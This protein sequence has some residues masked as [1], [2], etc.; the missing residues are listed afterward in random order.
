MTIDV[1]GNHCMIVVRCCKNAIT[2]RG[3]TA[4]LKISGDVAMATLPA[5]RYDGTIITRTVTKGLYPLNRR[6]GTIL[7]LR[8]VVR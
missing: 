2:Y 8:T 3:R 5:N 4:S 7:P 1:D 6:L